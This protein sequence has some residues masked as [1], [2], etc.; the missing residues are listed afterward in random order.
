MA[1]PQFRIWRGV[2]V[3]RWRFYLPMGGLLVSGQVAEPFW[4]TPG[5]MW[6]HGYTYSGHAAAA[7]VGIAN[8]DILEGEGLLDRGRELEDEMRAETW[9][10]VADNDVFPETFINFLG[11]D[12]HL[13]QV[14]IDAHAEVLT[15]DWWRGIQERLREGDE[16]IEAM[17]VSANSTVD[18]LMPA[19]VPAYS[20]T[21]FAPCSAMMR[22]SRAATSAMA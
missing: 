10:Y 16:P 20:A 4:T 9:Y 6:R 1:L 13:K 5:L 12:P 17:K 7:A 15:A 14:F 8:L 19:R 18:R 3:L 2:R 21:E 22:W 11:F